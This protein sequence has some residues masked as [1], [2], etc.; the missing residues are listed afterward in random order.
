LEKA[1][2]Q[3]G[4]QGEALGRR[5]WQ[6][7]LKRCLEYLR[8]GD[9]LLVTKIDRL[10]RSTSDLY[11]IISELTEKGVNHPHHVAHWLKKMLERNGLPWWGWTVGAALVTAVIVLGYRTVET[12]QQ[13]R[14]VQS[15]M[16][17]VTE[18]GVQAKTELGQLPE[19]LRL[20]LDNAEREIQ[21]LNEAATRAEASASERERQIAILRQGRA[22]CEEFF[23]GWGVKASPTS[24]VTLFGIA[25]E[26]T[27]A[28]DC[29]DK[30]DAGTAC[31]HW[32]GL[33]VQIEKIGS[34]VSESRVEIEKLMR[35]H[36]CK[37]I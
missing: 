31:R 9:T 23:D 20:K 36:R 8:E 13:L 33:L 17:S 2:V 18:D 37:K 24:I 16:D 15:E 22:S 21:R 14:A 35:Q 1:G 7:E 5:R 4:V 11:R 28:T 30:G 26:A 10:A 6:T 12:E 19:S 3:E 27:A 29:V 25:R 34:P 32:E